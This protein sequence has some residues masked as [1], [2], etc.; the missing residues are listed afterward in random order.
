LIRPLCAA[1]GAALLLAGCGLAAL[2]AWHLARDPLAAVAGAGRPDAVPFEQLLTAGC[3]AVLLGCVLWLGATTTLATASYLVTRLR[4]GS[5]Q[6]EA[7][8]DL[9]ERR[10]PPLIRRLVSV[11]LGA[12]LAAGTA[13]PALA[14]PPHPARLTGLA[15]PDRTTGA[16]VP[17]SAPRPAA[18]PPATVLVRPGD[19]LW[20]IAADRLPG[21]AGD[22]AVTRAWHRLHRAN[23]ARIGDDPDLIHPGTRLVVPDLAAPPRKDRP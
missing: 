22:A 12:A 3:A 20:S 16:V 19:S 9:A 14:E 15:V 21:S 1:L 4:P 8:R 6:A 11:A 17:A 10:C 23:L 7:V 5:A 2:G 18:P 13:G